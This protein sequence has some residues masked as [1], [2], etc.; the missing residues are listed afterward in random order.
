VAGSTHSGC[1]TNDDGFPHVLTGAQHSNGGGSDI[2]GLCADGFV[3]LL[4]SDLTTMQNSTYLG[5]NGVDVPTA[6]AVVSPTPGN[7]Q[8]YVAGLTT[9]TNFP[10]TPSSNWN[11]GMGSAQP[12]AGGNG[13]GFV[14]LLNASLSVLQTASYLGGR[15]GDGAYAI[16]A[17]S[18]YVYVGGRTTSSALGSNRIPAFPA[19]LGGPQPDYGGGSGVGDGFIAQLRPG[20]ASFG[21]N[22]YLGGSGDDQVLALA[23]GRGHT[24]FQTVVYA[25]GWTSSFNFPWTAGGAQP[26]LSHF[27]DGVVASL[28]LD[29]DFV[30]EPIEAFP[31]F[32][33]GAG[34]FVV[35]IAA[36]LTGPVDHTGIFQ[37]VAGSRLGLGVVFDARAR[38]RFGLH[39]GRLQGDWRP[40]AR[41]VYRQSGCR[42]R[43]QRQAG[44]CANLV[45]QGRY[46]HGCGDLQESAQRS[47]HAGRKAYQCHVHRERRHV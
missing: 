35:T 2:V 11:V 4:T 42:E 46:A 10:G 32:V 27:H 29:P 20:L 19:T 3:T 18:S 38:R 40:P 21:Q 30:V 43:A 23:L 14:A 8:V 37:P 16:V 13:D 39:R 31:I 9:S 34:T 36:D 17:S 28:S 25:A 12:Q 47:R 33:S 41:R 6:M 45:G 7:E 44:V 24:V 26:G 1:T 5:G 22:T 15:G